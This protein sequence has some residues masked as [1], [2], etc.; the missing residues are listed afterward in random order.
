[1][2][3]RYYTLLILLLSSPLLP[4][5]TIEQQAVLERE[6]KAAKLPAEAAVQNNTI[7]LD[8]DALPEDKAASILFNRLVRRGGAYD[9]TLI[10]LNRLTK[11][12]LFKK[13]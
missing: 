4:A 7:S 9:E 3:K 2:H 5:I 12:F 6:G 11:I 13:D 1:M 10:L 8:D